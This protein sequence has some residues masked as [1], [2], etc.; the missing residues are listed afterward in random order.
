[1]I[2]H[3][4]LKL[5]EDRET[6]NRILARL[7][8]ILKTES[9]YKCAINRVTLG[10]SYGEPIDSVCDKIIEEETASPWWADIL[11]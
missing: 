3:H 1:M 9:K 7:K 8:P 5:K 4:L 11:N 2:K 6:T 10:C